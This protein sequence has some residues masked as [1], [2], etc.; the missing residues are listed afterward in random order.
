MI[1]GH[2][3]PPD[4]P[5]I[6]GIRIHQIR[7][8][9][10]RSAQPCSIPL[11][12]GCRNH[13][14]RHRKSYSIRGIMQAKIIRMLG[15]VVPGRKRQQPLSV[16]PQQH[17]MTRLHEE[18]LL[19]R[20]KDTFESAIGAIGHRHAYRGRAPRHTR[21]LQLPVRGVA[22]VIEPILVVT[23]EHHRIIGV[24]PIKNTCLGGASHQ[25]RITVVGA[26]PAILSTVGRICH[27]YPDFRRKLSKIRPSVS[28][29]RNT[30]IV[31]VILTCGWCINDVWSIYTKDLKLAR[32]S[33]P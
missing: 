1:P 22:F 23:V 29:N 4:R 13:R 3:K 2:T 21:S 6:Y 16:R 28:P 15:A 25:H 9:E 18:F 30:G 10:A 5:G 11:K 19:F 20:V 8:I 31:Q 12:L 26:L 14:T 17:F 32:R 33:F 24:P 7:A 27:G